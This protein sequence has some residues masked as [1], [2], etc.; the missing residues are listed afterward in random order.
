MLTHNAMLNFCAL[1]A[2]QNREGSQDSERRPEKQSSQ[3]SRP[4]ETIPIRHHRHLVN[5][6]GLSGFCSGSQEVG[7]STWYQSIKG[8]SFSERCHIDL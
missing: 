3:P 1:K 5:V 6:K 2:L 8:P 7:D 4:I